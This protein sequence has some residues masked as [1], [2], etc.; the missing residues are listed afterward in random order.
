MST[1]NCGSLNELMTNG[2]ASHEAG[3]RSKSSCLPYN[4]SKTKSLESEQE[5]TTPERSCSSSH[6]GDEADCL[7]SAGLH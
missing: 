1:E 3:T 2:K 7:A 4:A 6:F 5:R